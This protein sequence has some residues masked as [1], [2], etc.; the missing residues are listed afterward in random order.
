M[1]CISIKILRKVKKT[2]V[3]RMILIIFTISILY[4]KFGMRKG[5]PD[6][7]LDF[8]KMDFMIKDNWNN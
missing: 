5:E 8:V 2:Q 7:I 1:G 6:K 3:E 4:M